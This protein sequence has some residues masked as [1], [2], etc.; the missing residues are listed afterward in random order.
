V[1]TDYAWRV[2]T[3]TTTGGPNFYTAPS[4]TTGNSGTFITVSFWVTAT[5]GTNSW[6]YFFGNSA[7]SNAA[8][9]HVKK[10]WYGYKNGYLS[11][12]GIQQGTMRN[13]GIRLVHFAFVQTVSTTSSTATLR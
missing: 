9:Q 12:G 11:N 7:A 10:R 3:I 1:I 2:S 6:Y 5:M 4:F 8:A 13:S